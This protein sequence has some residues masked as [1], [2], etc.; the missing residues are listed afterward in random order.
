MVLYRW[1]KVS[2]PKPPLPGCVE[3]QLLEADGITPHQGTVTPR[4]FTSGTM[5]YSTD[6][7]TGS[8]GSWGSVSSN[9]SRTSNTDRKIWFRGVFSGMS[10][11]SGN[12]GDNK[13]K[14][15]APKVKV[16]G[17]I[18][19]IL[20]Y[21]DNTKALAN[22]AFSTMFFQFPIIDAS[23]LS[24]PAPIAS[25]VCYHYMFWECRQL[26][27]GPVLPATTVGYESY[28]HMFGE[29]DSLKVVSIA[30]NPLPTD[31]IS[32]MFENVGT[33]GVLYAADPTNP[34]TPSGWTRKTWAERPY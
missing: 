14:T 13:W 32:T 4:W 12:S 16:R 3:F 1:P 25:N 10:L 31:S 20:D 23:E 18:N 11:Y 29:C 7:T 24:L 8:D 22:T 28:K 33:G 17:N 21:T 9:S 6:T 5:Q 15:S 26:V 30:A 27:N 34:P 19:N 2:P